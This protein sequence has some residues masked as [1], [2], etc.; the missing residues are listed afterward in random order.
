MRP[1]L[2]NVLPALAGVAFVFLSSGRPATAEDQP[3]F[4]LDATDILPESGREF[5]QTFTWTSGK[6]GQSF[7]GILGESEFEYGWSDQIK[8]AAKAEYDWTRTRDHIVVGAPA[9]EGAALDGIAGEAIYQIMNVYF[10]PIGLGILVSPG[11]GRNSRSLEAKALLQKNFLNDRL[12]AV[13]NIGG[14][15]GT[16]RS[17]DA[18]RD[19]SALTFDAG[20]AYNLTWEWSAVLEFNAEHDFDGLLINGRALPNASTFFVGPSV[21]YLAPPWTAALGVQ[22]QLPWASDASH[23]PGTLDH[24]FFSDAERF[25]VMLRIKRDTL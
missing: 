7:N 24:G 3:F 20:I 4:T 8:L 21:I 15:I 22:A 23:T 13:L 17:N 9:V 6:P 18:W 2:R 16:E 19:V 11:I 1:V 10:D 12:R 14:M 5:E 25:R